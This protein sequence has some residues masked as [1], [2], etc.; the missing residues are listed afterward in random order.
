MILGGAV[1]TINTIVIK[2]NVN[3]LV[4]KI[5]FFALVGCCSIWKE[6]RCLTIS[7]ALFLVILLVAQI[8]AGVTGYVLREDLDSQVFII[9][10]MA[11]IIINYMIFFG[12]LK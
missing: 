4:G 3:I 12:G 5:F 7:L 1:I 10:S 9:S 2:R 11:C 6:L 8:A